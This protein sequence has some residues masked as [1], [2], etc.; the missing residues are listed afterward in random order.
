MDVDYLQ[1]CSPLCCALRKILFLDDEG[2]R[3][4]WWSKSSGDCTGLFALSP[5]HSIPSCVLRTDKRLKQVSVP[6]TNS[7]SQYPPMI[8]QPVP[9]QQPQQQQPVSSL[10]LRRRRPYA[11]VALMVSS[12]VLATASQ[13]A[14]RACRSTRTKRSI[15]PTYAAPQHCRVHSEF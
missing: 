11:Q 7:Y 10:P 15:P 1:C 3:C 4:F 2:R 8:A 9:R 12:A 5:P 6:T 13:T 14:N